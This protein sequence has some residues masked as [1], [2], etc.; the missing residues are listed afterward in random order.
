M[1]HDRYD[2]A[3]FAAATEAVHQ[4][5]MKC[6]QTG[7]TYLLL[8]SLK[9]GDRFIA[10]APEQVALVQSRLHHL[11]V[12]DVEVIYLAPRLA[13]LEKLH[14]SNGKTVFD[15]SWVERLAINGIEQSRNFFEHYAD[16]VSG[17]DER[18]EATREKARKKSTNW[19]ES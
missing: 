12:Q 4:V 5:T 7:R 18:H 16:R 8:Q 15:H 9:P 17:F 3:A 13:E 11:G 14:T 1:T 2:L 10:C 6:R 19:E